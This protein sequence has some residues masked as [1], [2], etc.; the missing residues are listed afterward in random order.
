MQVRVLYRARQFWRTIFV[1]NSVGEL[2]KAHTWLSPAEWDLF[3][4]M[5]PAEQAHALRMLRL[6]VEKGEN[7]PDLLVAALLHDVGKLRYQLN[8]V[9]RA[10][11]VVVKTS[12]PELARRWGETSTERWDDIPGWRKAFIL[13]GQHPAWGA[14]LA[15]QAGVSPLAKELIRQ[16]QYPPRRDR[17]DWKTS[18]QYKLWVVDNDY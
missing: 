16:H 12:L 6:L 15:R 4:Q 1:K 7:Q 14:E 5:Q 18:L 10:L 3:T 8:P 17:D 2:E 9:E 11:V 13:A